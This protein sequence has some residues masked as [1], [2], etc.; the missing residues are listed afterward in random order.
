LDIIT[1]HRIGLKQRAIARKLG[2]SRNTVQK[3][4]ENPDLVFEP[5]PSR[6]RK[7][8]LDPF[9]DNIKAWIEEDSDYT[10]TW[11]YDR[12]SNMGF[13]GSYEIVKRRVHRIKENY[14]K[15]AYMRFETEPGYQAQVDFGE[16]QLSKPD[17]SITKL[18]L[19]SMILGYSRKM[20]AELIE[21]C[22]LPTFLDCHIHAFEYFGGVPEQILYDR[23]RNVYIGKIAGKKQFNNTLMGF[24]LHYGF[25]P[26]V[27]P[28]YAAWVKGKVERPYSFI[29]EGFW[30][31][32][33]FI[34]L[35]TANLDLLTW[36][37]KKDE[38]VHGTTH[39]VVTERFYRE[40]PHLNV[41]PPQAFDTSYRVYRKVYK[42]CTVRFE[43][44]SYVVPHDLVGKQ[45]ILRVK[46]KSMRI[47]YNNCLVIAYDIPEGKGHLVQDKRFYEALKKDREMNRRKYRSGRRMKG[48]AKYTISPSKP[49]YDMDVEVR[50]IFVYDQLVEE[51]RP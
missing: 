46:D 24:A 33:G 20:Y 11:I 36:L 29:R 9:S 17:G 21:R 10:A 31:G 28:A 6:N 48:R 13:T 41:L 47:F 43:G 49:Q 37:S 50:P 4:I 7:S 22:D 12:L 44:N 39:E 23:M 15:V 26:E 40:K 8:R 30:R 16:F 2:I 38:R 42:D 3:Y 25:K 35:E 1:L 45:I 27:A 32:Y 18:F 19:F 5:S 14:H 51:V 34:C